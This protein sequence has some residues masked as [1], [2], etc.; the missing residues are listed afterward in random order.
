[1]KQSSY[2]NKMFKTKQKILSYFK[3]NISHTDSIKIVT[4]SLLLIQDDNALQTA[5]EMCPFLKT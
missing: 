1:M 2:K 4:D 5:D 3:L